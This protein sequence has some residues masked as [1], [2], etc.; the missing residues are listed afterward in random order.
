[1]AKLN[2]S[3]RS[4]LILGIV[5]GVVVV[6]AIFFAIWYGGAAAI[7]NGQRISRTEFYNLALSRAGADVLDELITN[8]LIDQEA[9][10]NHV[11]IDQTQIDQR[12]QEYK[13]S[14]AGGDDSTWQAVLSQYGMTEASLRTS[15]RYELIAD[16]IIGKDITVTDD[17]IAT[18]YNDNKTNYSDPE[19]VRASHILVSTKEEADAILS[20]LKGGADFAALAKEKSLDTTSAASG[21]DLGYFS[22]GQMDAD[23]ETAAFALPV[24]QL[25][26]P[27]QTQYGYHIIKVIDHKQAKD[28]TLDE[29]KDRV[30]QDLINSKI[31]D[32]YPDWVAG[33]KAKAKIVQYWKSGS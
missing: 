10:K 12:L 24:G 27:V 6:A 16:A 21:G 18:Y 5:A 14:T 29:V 9:A 31:S 22:K 28:Y 11:T 13:N 8:R 26:D 19:Q 4:K 32:Q 1:M 20:Q 3:S 30:R 7:V 17:E 23:F 15:I 2:L 25:S 33:L